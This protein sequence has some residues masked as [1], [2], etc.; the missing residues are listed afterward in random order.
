LKLAAPDGPHGASLLRTPAAAIRSMLS[1]NSAFACL[2]RLLIQVVPTNAVC[3][4]VAFQRVAHR[5]GDV[6]DIE[7]E[8]PA[9][10]LRTYG[11][12]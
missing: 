12:K 6:I 10:A 8:A 2:Q 7:F 9:I 1:R 3:H 5:F 4:L 11:L